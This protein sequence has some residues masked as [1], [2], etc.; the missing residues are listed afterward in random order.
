MSGIEQLKGKLTSK[1]GIAMAN[2]FAVTLPSIGDMDSRELNVICKEVT[3]PGR[4]VMS[5]DRNVG[6]F[7]EKVANG[8]AV[9]DVSMTFYVLNDYGVKKYFDAWAGT[10]VG[11]NYKSKP[12][13]A[14]ED[15]EPEAKAQAKATRQEFDNTLKMGEVGYKNNYSK[16]ITIR[17]LRKPVARFGFDLGP[18]D[19]N[20][21][22][23]G[24]S[25]YSIELL[26]A[27]P[28]S[29]NS[30]QLSNDGQLVECTLQFSYTNWKVIEDK[31]SLVDGKLNL[32]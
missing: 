11:M 32:I 1:N 7:N 30:I 4:Q 26:E 23:G 18:I 21:D 15:A 22:V 16:N 31:R 13:E 6:L 20:F 19:F 25:I 29:L 28:T 24:A 12:E 14:A 9:E 8:F 17:Q 10:M 3:L 27:F 2:Q 5:L